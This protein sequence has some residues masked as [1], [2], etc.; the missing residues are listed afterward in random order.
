MKLIRNFTE[1]VGLLNRGSVAE[2]LD[3]AMAEII[4]TLENLPKGEGKASLTLTL[5]FAYQG[6]RVDVKPTVKSK[7]MARFHG[8]SR[9]TTA[10]R[11]S[12]MLLKRWP[13]TP[14]PPPGCRSTHP[15]RPRS[16]P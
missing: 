2:R 10:T 3:E 1:T 8:H 14:P 12:A 9:F 5:E 6:S 13:T 15:H 7:L 11:C 16:D 4:E